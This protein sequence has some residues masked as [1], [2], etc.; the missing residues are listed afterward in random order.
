[1]GAKTFGGAKKFG[2]PKK[3]GAAKKFEG[4][5]KFERPD[6]AGKGK[7]PLNRFTRDERPARDRSAARKDRE[8]SRDQRPE[9]ESALSTRELAPRA[10]DDGRF[11][12]GANPV[13]EALRA[14]PDRIE[15]ILMQDGGLGPKLAAEVFTRVRD[16]GIRLDKVD[17]DRLSSMS[18]G[19]VHQGIAAE[20]RQFDYLELEQLIKISKSSSRA[21]LIVVLDGI[22][23]PHNLGAI[24]RSAHAFGAHGV[25]IARDRAAGVTGVVAKSSAGA[26]EY[27]PIARVTNL[28]R[29]LEELKKNDF[30]T[31]A[32]EPDGDRTLWAADLKG[33]IVI[34]V[35]AEGP[36]VREG[37]L[38]QCDYRVQIPMVG[39]VASLNASVSA[40][41]LLAEVSRQRSLDGVTAAVAAVAPAE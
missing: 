10:S 28:S 29:A 16:A 24:I 3:F 9:R 37:V 15:R 23:D 36:G 27:C 26:I 8:Q 19:G 13:L 39:K 6:R 18:D 25:V 30:W 4:G 38:K 20:V 14:N 35:G 41:V 1:M 32:A 33:P 7:R 17:R 31:V 11:I 34:V 2:G 5:K 12:W 40:G 22:Q 21:P